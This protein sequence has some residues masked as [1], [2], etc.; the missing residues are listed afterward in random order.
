MERIKRWLT[1]RLVSL[2]AK[3]HW[4]MFICLCE[5]A[6]IAHHRGKIEEAIRD[7]MRLEQEHN[8]DNQEEHKYDT[9]H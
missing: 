2:A 4:D 7:V 9:F 8:H 6:I 5:T 3:L 1:F